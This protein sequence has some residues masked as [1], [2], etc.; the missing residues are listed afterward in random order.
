MNVDETSVCLFQ[1]TAKGT[2]MAGKRLFDDATANDG[3]REPAQKISRLLAIPLAKWI[4]RCFEF[5]S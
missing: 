2:V 1:S 3:P 5:K 4:S